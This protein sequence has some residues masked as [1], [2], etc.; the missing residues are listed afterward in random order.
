MKILVTGSEGQLGWELLRQGDE[1]GFEIVPA[2][3]PEV[4]ITR[5]DQVS[6]L[7]QHCKPSLLIN[8]AAYTNVDKAETDK[9]AAFAVNRDGSAVLARQCRIDKIPLIHVST[10]FVFDGLKKRPY[11]ENDPIAP[12]GVY[13]QSKAAG[14]EV[15]R[16]QLKNHIIVR[17]AWLYGVHGHNFVKTM[18]R[19]AQERET[20]RV[21]DD[22]YGCPTSAF[23]LAEALLTIAGRIRDNAEIT[24]GT[25]HF[26]GKGIATW[27]DFTKEIVK[28]AESYSPI[29]TTHITP[30]TTDE[31]PTDAARPSYS[32]L[33]CGLIE[34]RFGIIPKPWQE[35]LKIAIDRIFSEH[36]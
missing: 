2:D 22:Q 7:L 12:I 21:V 34:K 10:D 28:S 8:A 25:F 6:Q 1:L 27:F 15:V 30:V 24:F 4:D 18:L 29:K 26:C 35:S 17:T 13:G 11:L 23:D 3:L 32:A 9:K 16:A 20:I 33:D 19:L 31:F 5:S 14:E 36:Q